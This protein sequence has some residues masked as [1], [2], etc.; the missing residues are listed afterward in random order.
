MLGAQYQREALVYFEHVKALIAANASDVI[1]AI[2]SGTFPASPG[3][4]LISIAAIA[5]I[6]VTATI[7][8]VRG[9]VAISYTNFILV[10]PI[11]Y[12]IVH[13]NRDDDHPS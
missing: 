12:D 1:A 5:M 3:S 4:V 9:D 13:V 7:V 10:K 11:K 8:A 6:A 2:A